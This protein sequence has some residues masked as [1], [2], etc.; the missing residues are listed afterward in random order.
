MTLS[1]LTFRLSKFALKYVPAAPEFP[2]QPIL[3]PPVK[4]NTK[5]NQR[6]RDRRRGTVKWNQTGKI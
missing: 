3:K 2:G 1:L 6:S 4:T 5:E